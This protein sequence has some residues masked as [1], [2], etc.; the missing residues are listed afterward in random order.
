DRSGGVH[1]GSLYLAWADEQP[2]GSRM[3]IYYARSFDG[4]AHWSAPAQVDTGNANDAWQPAVSVDQSNGA[5]TIAWYDR[6]DDSG[7]KLYRPYYTQSTDGGATFLTRQV[8]VSTSSS[9]PTL[10]CNGTG[11]YMQMTSVD[12][13]AHPF[14]SDTRN[15]VNQIFTAAVDEATLAQTLVAPPSLFA[16][17]INTAADPTPYLL[18]VGDFNNDGI[19]DVAVG[20]GT[21]GNVAILLGTGDGHFQAP[22]KTIVPGGVGVLAAGDFNKDGKLDLAVTTTQIDTAGTHGAVSILPGKGDGTF[23]TPIT[24]LSGSAGA[25]P[26]AVGDLNKDGVLDLVVGHGSL[27]GLS[28]FLGNG[29]GSFSS[30][31]MYPSSYAAA[32]FAVA[33]VNDDGKLDLAMTT[34]TVV[35][36]WPGNGDGTLQSPAGYP[37]GSTPWA[38]AVAD[39]NGD[40]ASD[41]AVANYPQAMFSVLINKG[42]G[43]GTFKPAVGY[44]GPAVGNS[45]IATGDFN[46]DGTADIALADQNTNGVSI[47]P[48]RGDGS[49]DRAGV[50]PAGAGP[51]VIRAADLNSDH[52]DDLVVANQYSN[53]VSILMSV[54]RF[55][56]PQPSGLNF[57]EQAPHATSPAQT[58]TLLNNGTADLRV[59][60]AEVRGPDPRDFVKVGDSC[61]GATVPAG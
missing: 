16:S 55:A 29:D 57:P 39:F 24:F 47:W 17:P 43:S 1:T 9:D 5:L 49:F 41:I 48:G 60:M 50:Y 2:I 40:G 34:G 13:V 51:Y 28:V 32:D 45:A 23:G 12:G 18:A 44:G 19:P 46:R 7:N 3:H 15:G 59:A 52:R 33:D 54:T 25:G 6:R 26:L 36:V 61:S 42:D 56:V 31:T 21:A 53:N 58:M 4:G 37:A 38:M 10:N 20:N 11:D 8:P 27:T 14:W 30:P 22:I 35:Q